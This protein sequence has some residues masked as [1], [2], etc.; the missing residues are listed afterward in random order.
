MPLRVGKY[1][2]NASRTEIDALILAIQSL[3]TDAAGVI[4]KSTEIEFIE[5]VKAGATQNIYEQLATFCDKQM[6]KAIVGQ[7]ATSEG[8]PGGLGSEQARENV[9]LDLIRADAES[10]S[11]TIRFQVFRPL[12][13][14]NFGWD[15]PLPWFK[16]KYER[17]KDLQALSKV[18]KGLSEI[19][20]PLQLSTSPN[21]SRCRCLE[22]ERQCSKAHRHSC[23]WRRK[24]YSQRLKSPEGPCLCPGDER[25]EK[26]IRLIVKGGEDG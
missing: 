4:S 10:I 20:Y 16:I 19:G 2:Q 3:G 11:K 15:K 18:Y 14:Y 25:G 7:T 26:I 23:L 24:I 13:G 5:T 21:A 12:V 9:R 8:T 17:G 1:E 22:P 6:S